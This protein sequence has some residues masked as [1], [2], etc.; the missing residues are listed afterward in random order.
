MARNRVQFWNFVNTAMNLRIRSVVNKPRSS[1][2]PFYCIIMKKLFN[3]FKT[4]LIQHYIWKFSSYREE[5]TVS[6]Q[7]KEQLVN[8]VK[9]SLLWRSYRGYFFS[10][11]NLELDKTIIEFLMALYC[12]NTNRYVECTK[13]LSTINFYSS[14]RTNLN[15][16]KSLLRLFTLH[17]ARTATF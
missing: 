4:K 1:G 16:H 15:P 8:T 6:I 10:M 17:I 11:L 2:A 5:N 12:N 9:Q 7:Y 3:H 14:K 13:W